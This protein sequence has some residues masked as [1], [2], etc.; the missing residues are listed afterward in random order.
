MTLRS[1]GHFISWKND[2]IDAV[3]KEPSAMDKF[4]STKIKKTKDKTTFIETE[5]EIKLKHL[6]I[7]LY[8]YSISLIIAFI[9]FIIETLISM[10]K[11]NKY[12]KK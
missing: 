6:S 4:N 8:I 9:A 3:L 10:K 5:D 11:S 12:K 7:V 2:A 1:T